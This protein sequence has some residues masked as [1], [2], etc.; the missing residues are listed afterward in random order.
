MLATNEKQILEQEN[1]PFLF[2]SRQEQELKPFSSF[3]LKVMDIPTSSAE[4]ERFFSIYKRSV[5]PNRP[6][7]EDKKNI[8]INIKL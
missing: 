6:R 3:A 1:D 4:V 2:F 5:S 8:K 7:L